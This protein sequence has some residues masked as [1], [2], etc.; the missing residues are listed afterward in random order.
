MEY[1]NPIIFALAVLLGCAA[2]YLKKWA[3][4]QTNVSF[5]EWFGT[6]NLK[7]SINTGFAVGG[8]IVSPIVSGMISPSMPIYSVLWM[9]LTAG[10]VVDSTFNDDGATNKPDDT[11]EVITQ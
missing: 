4:S 9:G 11:H 7:A 3:K 1:L 2:H 10:W 6:A 8:A 5:F